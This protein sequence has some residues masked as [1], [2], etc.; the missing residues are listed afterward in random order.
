MVLAHE[1]VLRTVSVATGQPGSLPVSAWPTDTYS[2]ESKDVSANGEAVQ[3]FHQPAANTDGDTVI[4]FRR[5]DVVV[6]GDIYSTTSYPVIDAA[7]GGTFRGSLRVESHHRPDRGQGLAGRRHDGDSGSR[8]RGRRVGR[9]RI[10]RHADDHSRP[11][12]GPD[13]RKA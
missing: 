2:G 8:P 10:P 12:P 3:L 4:L 5:S 6:T 13:S 1:A 11:H 9:R 7:R